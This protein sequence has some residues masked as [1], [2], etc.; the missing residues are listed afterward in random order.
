M[1]KAAADGEMTLSEPAYQVAWPTIR[2]AYRAF[3][4][5]GNVELEGHDGSVQLHQLITFGPDDARIIANE[6]SL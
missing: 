3:E 2:R 4:P 6:D 1:E 5:A